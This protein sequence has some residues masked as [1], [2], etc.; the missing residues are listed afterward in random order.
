MISIFNYTYHLNNSHIYTTH[1]TT[2][3][4]KISNKNFFLFLILSFSLFYQKNLTYKIKMEEEEM[5]I[6]KIKIFTEKK[7]KGMNLNEDL[8]KQKDFLNPS[9]LEK[10]IENFEIEEVKKIKK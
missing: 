9:I 4:K 6:E 7:K 5:L 10:I 8:K 1:P 3:K 2:H